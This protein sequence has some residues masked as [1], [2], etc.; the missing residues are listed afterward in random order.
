[1][2][3]EG[4]GRRSLLVHIFS[5]APVLVLMQLTCQPIIR[6]LE[7]SETPQVSQLWRD[8]SWRKHAKG[9]YDGTELALSATVTGHLSPQGYRSWVDFIATQ[10]SESVRLVR[11]MAPLTSDRTRSGSGGCCHGGTNPRGSYSYSAERA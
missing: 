11:L 9:T 4:R 5:R 6:E 10:K 7:S 2:T 3:Q 1:M 8:F